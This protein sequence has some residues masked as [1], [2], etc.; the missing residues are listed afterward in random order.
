MGCQAIN[1]NDIDYTEIFGP[2]CSGDAI[3]W[4]NRNFGEARIA[5]K[6]LRYFLYFN[7][8]Y[9]IVS[10]KSVIGSKYIYDYHIF[11]TSEFE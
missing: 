4:N 8:N 3:V 1:T 2:C 9:V 7:D 6:T 11:E 5:I 10:K